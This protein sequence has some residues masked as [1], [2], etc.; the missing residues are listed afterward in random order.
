[1]QEIGKLIAH[2][3]FP[4]CLLWTGQARDRATVGL[5]YRTTL[6]CP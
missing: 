4:K 6:E 1:M 5:G 3:V 2:K